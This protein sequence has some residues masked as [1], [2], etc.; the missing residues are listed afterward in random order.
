MIKIMFKEKYSSANIIFAVH[1]LSTQMATTKKLL[2][3]A[4]LAILLQV[5][6]YERDDT[7]NYT[8]CFTHPSLLNMLYIFL[9]AM[10]LEKVNVIYCFIYY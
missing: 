3:Y 7:V 10:G 9:G 1:R 5:N 8:T 6:D 4:V 2:C